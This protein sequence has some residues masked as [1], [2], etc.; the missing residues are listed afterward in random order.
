MRKVI[1][2]LILLF[3]FC[4][5]AYECSNTDMERYQKLANNV[6]FVIE[7][8]EN[9][10][11]SVV[12]SG[13]SKDIRI[14]NPNS[15]TY[16]WNLTPNYIGETR[17]D[18]LNVGKTYNFEIFTFSDICLLKKF[19]IITVNIPNKNPYYEDEICKDASEYSLCQKWTKVDISYNEFVK[20][21]SE[22]IKNKNNNRENDTDNIKTKTFDFFEFYE[23]YYWPM[24]ICMICILGVL[25][26]LWIKENKKNKL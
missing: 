5:K 25:I 13:V 18:N 10:T 15:R 6:S 26:I 20:K 1:M 2:C 23:R 19:R 12:F 11:F 9:G 16:Y 14:Y 7:E 8:Q 22:Y 17:A 24:F 21:V 4:I 3:P